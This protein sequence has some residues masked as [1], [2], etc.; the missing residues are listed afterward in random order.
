MSKK[1]KENMCGIVFN[2]GCDEKDCAYFK[3]S[4]IP[5][6][7]SFELFS[8]CGSSV[9]RANAIILELK[10]MGVGFMLTGRLDEIKSKLKL[11]VER[12]GLKPVEEVLKILDTI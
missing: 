3:E 2:C 9:A 12:N 6:I 10:K 8:E 7:C 4:V 5:G 1:Q 11:A